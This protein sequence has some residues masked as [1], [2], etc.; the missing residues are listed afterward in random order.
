MKNMIWIRE[1][2]ITMASSNPPATLT[3]PPPPPFPPRQV[4]EKKNSPGIGLAP[5]LKHKFDTTDVK[6]FWK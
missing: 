1:I 4:A 5:I 3:A 6:G 2:I